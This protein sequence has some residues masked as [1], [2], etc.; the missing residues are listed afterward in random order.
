MKLP[1]PRNPSPTQGHNWKQLLH[2]HTTHSFRVN[3]HTWGHADRAGLWL[4]LPRIVITCYK[5]TTSLSPLFLLV[6]GACVSVCV[7]V[8]VVAGLDSQRGSVIILIR[9]DKKLKWKEYFWLRIKPLD[10]I[11]CNL[12]AVSPEQQRY[13][14]LHGDQTLVVVV[15]ASRL[16]RII[17]H[18]L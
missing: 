17:F 10:P 16:C 14:S 2:L 3:V 18:T 7:Y 11:Y 13:K 1:I 15:V 9:T 5:L 4:M 8:G 6:H 12:K